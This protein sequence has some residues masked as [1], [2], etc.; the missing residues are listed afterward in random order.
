MRADSLPDEPQ[1]K[2]EQW[3]QHIKFIMTPFA[4]YYGL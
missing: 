2:P 1:G 3:Q 4:G